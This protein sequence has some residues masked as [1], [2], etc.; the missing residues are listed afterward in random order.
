MYQRNRFILQFM[1]QQNP[2]FTFGSRMLQVLD[3]AWETKNRSGLRMINK[4]MKEF[5]SILP[6]SQQVVLQEQLAELQLSH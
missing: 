3:E 1:I 5:V 6:R 2:D 4:D